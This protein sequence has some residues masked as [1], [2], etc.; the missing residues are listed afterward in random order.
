MADDYYDQD[1]GEES[2]IVDEQV[3]VPEEKLGLVP[4]SFFKDKVKP[5]DREKIEVVKIYDNEVAIKCIYGDKDKDDR[6][7]D[8]DDMDMAGP[9][10]AEADEL[11]G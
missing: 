4:M 6:S 5:G 11:M 3:D 7:E 2:A 1:T 8:D 9:S 10:E